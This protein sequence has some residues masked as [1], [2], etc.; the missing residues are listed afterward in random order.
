V[1]EERKGLRGEP[2]FGGTSS[3]AGLGVPFLSR[4]VVDLWVFRMA[5][6]KAVR[7]KGRV[8]FQRNALLY[9]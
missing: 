6:I 9:S 8:F 4:H 5:L 7:E 3:F 2:L 1:K